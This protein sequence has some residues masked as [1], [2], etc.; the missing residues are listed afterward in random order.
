MTQPHIIIRFIGSPLVTLVL[1]SGSGFFIYGWWT[2]HTVWWVALFAVGIIYRTLQA[3]NRMRN[4]NAWVA[5]R[6][7]LRAEVD[8]VPLPKNKPTTRAR[9]L[10]AVVLVVA[11]SVYLGQPHPDA[12]NNQPLT[13]TLGFILAAA[14][15]Y[16]AWKFIA[17]F[18]RKAYG[19]VTGRKGRQAITGETQTDAPVTWLVGRASSSPSRAQAQ[20][21][22]P[23]YCA[24]LIAPPGDANRLN[25]GQA[26]DRIAAR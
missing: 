2:G 11:I 5:E 15:L 18:G 16:L 22:L 19:L 24:R 1:L 21:A 7:A 4:Y 3:F 8:G 23:E 14:S 9:V 20:K 12:A 17:F 26:R 13:T 10:I 6:R 25:A